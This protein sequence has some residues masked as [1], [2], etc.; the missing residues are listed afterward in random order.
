M[1]Q[2]S[3]DPRHRGYAEPEGYPHEGM[4][5]LAATQQEHE[6]YVTT[7]LHGDVRAGEGQT[8]RSERLG[9]C[10]GHHQAAEHGRDDQQLY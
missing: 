1:R 4:L 10:G 6:D 9:R 2:R 5:L 3:A 8:F 7:D